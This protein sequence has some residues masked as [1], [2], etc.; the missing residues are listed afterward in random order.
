MIAS[1]RRAGSKT[2]PRRLVK[3]RLASLTGLGPFRLPMILEAEPA[4]LGP[5]ADESRVSLAWQAASSEHPSRSRVDDCAGY[6]KRTRAQA[7]LWVG[8]AVEDSRCVGGS[9]VA[10]TRQKFSLAGRTTSSQE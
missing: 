10:R 1:G 7:R 6:P 4:R 3:G 9:K 8:Q 5:V 2:S